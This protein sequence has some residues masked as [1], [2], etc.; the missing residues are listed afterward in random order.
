VNPALRFAEEG[1]LEVRVRHEEVDGVRPEIAAEILHGELEHAGVLVPGVRLLAGE[2]QRRHPGARGCERQ[3]RDDRR[4]STAG[5]DGAGPSPGSGAWAAEDLHVDELGEQ[6][7]GVQPER[8]VVVAGDD[9]HLGSASAYANQKS[10]H[11]LLRLGGRVPAF[12]DVPGVEDE[13]DGFPFDESREVI[14]HSL[15]LV[16]ALDALPS[17]ADVPVACVNDPHGQLLPVRC[18]K[19]GSLRQL[20]RL[21]TP[22]TPP[23]RI[24][25]SP[26]SPERA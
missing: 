19:R 22:L 7:A 4:L 8:I 14:E 1:S 17:A 18:S 20:G 13:V 21:R 16:E 10:V 6:R 15:Q 25:Y 5:L 24:R 11:E 2:V 12:E 9:E 3:C 23:A 26:N